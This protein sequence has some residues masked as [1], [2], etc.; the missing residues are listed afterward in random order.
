MLGGDFPVAV[1]AASQTLKNGADRYR[2]V[3]GR[4]AGSR[5]A[6]LHTRHTPLSAVSNHFG[7]T[8]HSLS[9]P[10]FWMNPYRLRD[11]HRVK[12]AHA[13]TRIQAK[14]SGMTRKVDDV[15]L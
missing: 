7:E 6:T 12:R 1:E 14:I 4:R 8:K 10:L 9:P 5:I 2:Q 15:K 13:H 11:L 3:L